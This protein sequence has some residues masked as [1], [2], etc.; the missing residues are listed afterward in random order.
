MYCVKYC[1][2]FYSCD[3]SCHLIM[4]EFYFLIMLDFCW[5]FVGFVCVECYLCVYIAICVN[6]VLLMCLQY[7]FCSYSAIYMCT[8]IISANDST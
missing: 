2:N 7:Y 8:L 3:I 4:F 5:T 1:R 6:T